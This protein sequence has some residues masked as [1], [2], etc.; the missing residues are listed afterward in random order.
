MILKLRVWFLKKRLVVSIGTIG[1]Q[2]EGYENRL[3]N[4]TNQKSLQATFEL[5]GVSIFFWGWKSDQIQLNL[6][7]Q[8][9]LFDSIYVCMIDMN[10]IYNRHITYTFVTL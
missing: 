9:K 6:Y 5:K 3:H 1:N 2:L 8:S 10:T 7:G 4:T